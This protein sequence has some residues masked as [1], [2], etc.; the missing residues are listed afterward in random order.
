MLLHYAGEKGFSRRELG[1]HVKGA[2]SSITT[3]L[4]R[5][6]SAKYRQV[7]QLTDGNYRLT[8]IGSKRIRE[9]LTDALRLN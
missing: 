6:S 7:I 4:Q 3:A 8:D 9:E 5:L 2:P 1:I